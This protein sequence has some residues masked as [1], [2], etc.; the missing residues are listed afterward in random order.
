MTPLLAFDLD[1]VKLLMSM[2]DTDR[3]GTI[4]FNEFAGLWRYIKDWYTFV[5]TGLVA[6]LTRTSQARCLP[7]L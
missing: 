7:P 2:F 4:G 6:T 3:S 1:T 5:H